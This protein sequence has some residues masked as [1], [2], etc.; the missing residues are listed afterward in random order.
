MTKLSAVL[1]TKNESANIAACMQTLALANEIVVLDTGSEDD[2]IQIAQALG[3]QVYKQESWEGFGKAKQQ[4]VDLATNDWI[5][6]IDA[7]ERLSPELQKELIALR[8]RDF[9]H[10][11]WHLRR[12]SYYLGKPIRFCGWQN[13]APLRVFDRRKGGF[14]DLIVH[15]GIKV[16]QDKDTCRHLMHH[17]TY[18]TLDSHFRKIHFYA[19]LADQKKESSLM[20]ALRAAHKFFKMY[21]VN[22]G[23]LDGYSGFLLCKN[24]AWGIWYKYK[25]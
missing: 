10:K 18:P 12:R 1:I 5:L 2:T 6:S 15:E 4:A 19:E 20:A 22:L 11:A 25:R 16:Q 23:F 8:K 21:I 7:D 3:A 17:L 14:N 13:D 9:E 24:S